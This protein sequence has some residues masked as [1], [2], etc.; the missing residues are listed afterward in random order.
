MRSG[1]GTK[2]GEPGL[3]TFSTKATIACFGPVSF[4]DGSGSAARAAV[5]N[6]PSSANATAAEASRRAVLAAYFPPPA[7]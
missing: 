7:S 4:Q 2:S 6:A 1:T 3:A 5:A